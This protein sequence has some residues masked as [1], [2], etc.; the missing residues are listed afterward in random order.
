MDLQQD[1]NKENGSDIEDYCHSCFSN[2]KDVLAAGF[3]ETCNDFLCAK[4]FK[5]HT[6]PLPSRNHVL[7]DK[8]SM[9]RSAL[10][11]RN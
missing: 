3:R 6:M 4:C 10:K 9:H 5:R 2:G 1:Q 11:A 7:I 8:A